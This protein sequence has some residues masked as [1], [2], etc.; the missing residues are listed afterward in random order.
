MKEVRNASNRMWIARQIRLGNCVSCAKPNKS[1][2][3]RCDACRIKASGHQR[4][5]RDRLKKVHLC[6]QCGKEPGAV[7]GLHA[8]PLDLCEAC[9]E[10]SR[11]RSMEWKRRRREQD[12][13]TK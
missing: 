5:R 8:L 3:R 11:T 9:T 7:R 12:S 6:T 4:K 2:F 1:V 10:D 13:E